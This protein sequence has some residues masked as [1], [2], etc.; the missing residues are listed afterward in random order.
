MIDGFGQISVEMEEE[1]VSKK[2]LNLRVRTGADEGEL[3]GGW[4]LREKGEH[5]DFLK[6]K[7]PVDIGQAGNLHEQGCVHVCEHTCG[8]T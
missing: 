3:E 6:R 2:D 5:L 1:E 8:E 4:G 7:A